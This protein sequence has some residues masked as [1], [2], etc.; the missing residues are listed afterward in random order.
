M[1]LSAI[2][3]IYNKLKNIRAKRPPVMNQ[4]ER[5]LDVLH[6]ETGE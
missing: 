1:N 5:Q 2:A 4:Q 3:T 6:P